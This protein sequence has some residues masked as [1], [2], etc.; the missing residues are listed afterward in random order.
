MKYVMVVILSIGFL[1]A[2]CFAGEKLEL[3]DLKDKE[4]YI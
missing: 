1:F 2:N 4:S 3:K